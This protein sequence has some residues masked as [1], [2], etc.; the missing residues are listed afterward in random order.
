MERAFAGGGQAGASHHSNSFFSLSNSGTA[1]FTLR[2]E[3]S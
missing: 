1:D 2:S 3:D